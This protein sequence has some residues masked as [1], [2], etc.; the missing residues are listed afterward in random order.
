VKASSL[1]RFDITGQVSTSIVNELM[2]E[3]LRNGVGNSQ[4]VEKGQGH[5]KDTETHLCNWKYEDQ[6]LPAKKK[7]IFARCEAA[8]YIMTSMTPWQFP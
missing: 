7:E 2:L 6:D 1:T 3:D 8:L 5:G 4:T